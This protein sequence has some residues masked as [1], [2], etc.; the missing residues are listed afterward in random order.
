MLSPSALLFQHKPRCLH[1]S[2]RNSPYPTRSRKALSRTTC[3]D[4]SPRPPTLYDNDLEDH[5]TPRTTVNSI[6]QRVKLDHWTEPN[7][8]C[9][10]GAQNL[11]RTNLGSRADKEKFLQGLVRGGSFDRGCPN[12][13]PHR[14]SDESAD[15][16]FLNRKSFLRLVQEQMMLSRAVTGCMCASLV[17]QY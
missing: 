4:P 6:L 10:P 5:D 17:G 16:K 8:I 7:E 2:I 14:A 1:N 9:W 15:R 11:A 3:S 12:L 13:P